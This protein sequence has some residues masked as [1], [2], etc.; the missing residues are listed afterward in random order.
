MR[1]PEGM[2][3]TSPFVGRRAEATVLSAAFDGTGHEVVLVTGDAGIGKSRL[4]AEVI[5][6][7]RTYWCCPVPRCRCRNRSR[8]G[9]SWT[10]W[11]RSVRARGGRTS[12]GL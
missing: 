10:R 11:R 6:P 5:A 8:T 12:T 2:A 1:C 7:S 3:Q 4:V 9:R